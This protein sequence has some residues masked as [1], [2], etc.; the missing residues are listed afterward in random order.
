VDV[1]SRR[2]EEVLFKVVLG[3]ETGLT[4]PVRTSLVNK[5]VE[6]EL[7]RVLALNLLKLLLK[8]N[9]VLRN[10]TIKERDLG[11][12]GRVLG[13][14]VN[15]LEERGNAGTTA[16]ETNLLVLVGKVGVLGNGSLEGDSVVDVQAKDVVTKLT[17]LVSLDE[18][19]ESARGLEIRNGSVRSDDIATLSGDKLGQKTGS[20]S[21]AESLVLGELKGEFLGLWKFLSLGNAQILN[22]NLSSKQLESVEK[23]MSKNQ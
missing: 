15:Q 1:V 13:D 6:L 19:S 2:R 11:L 21:E 16:N 23:R 12:V 3:N 8:Q 14:S 5:E 18:D 20:V 22:T 4:L 7:L 17:S 9:V 10:A